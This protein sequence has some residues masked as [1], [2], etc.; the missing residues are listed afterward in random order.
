MST[1]K[2]DEDFKKSLVTLHQNGKTQAQL[3]R[4]YGVSESA[5]C[6]WVKQYA[7]V[8]T[9]D[10]EVLTA[11]Q[12]KELQ[13]RNAQLEEENQIYLAPF[14][15]GGSSLSRSGRS[16][17]ICIPQSRPSMPTAG[18]RMPEVRLEKFTVH[19]PSSPW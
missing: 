7:T 3:C 19:L 11:K 12:V 13:K 5:L 6:K 17:K 8:Q 10:G 9:D 14:F 2:Y 1:T 18:I 16:S 15:S 4:E